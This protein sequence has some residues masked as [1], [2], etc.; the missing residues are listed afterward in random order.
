MST[1]DDMNGIFAISKPSGIT[2]STFLSKIQRI[3]TNSSVFASDLSELRGQK[4]QQLQKE[5]KGKASRRQL[6]KVEKVKIGHGG[7]LDPLASGVLVVGV[8]KGTKR[9]Q[10]YLNGSVKVYETEALFGIE[11][12][13]A[14][15]EGDV[16]LKSGYDHI[17]KE[18]LDSVPEK[19]LGTIKQTPPIFS[20][21]K[22][23]GKP[24]Y[25]YA[26]NNIALPKEIKSRE[27][28]VY[29]L[30]IFKDSLS[31]DYQHKG[32]KA[33]IDEEMISEL[34][35]N[36]T[37]KVD[38]HKVFYSKEYCAK[39]GLNPEEKQ[40]PG[41]PHPAT[42]STDVPPMLH[43][44]TKV[45]SGTYIRSLISDVA[46]SVQANAYMVKLIR[47]KQA[48]WDLNTNVFQMED[49][50]NRDD[51]VWGDVLRRVLHT[52]NGEDIKDLQI[53]F[54]EA[55]EKYKDQIEE[56]KR[57][58]EEREKLEQEKEE[59]KKTEQTGDEAATEAEKVV[60]EEAKAADVESEKKTEPE[61]ANDKKRPL[62]E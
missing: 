40:D 15:V 13:S 61:E 47:E 20:A 44:K 55:E 18:D 22:V 14:D 17:T 6:R 16:L 62:E 23:N 60:G 49:F 3:F 53:W 2:S 24:L 37:L 12:T 5:N 54:K 31:R 56:K 29:E 10:N 4:I 33:D 43:F 26:R 34:K 38:F 46:K 30:E 28:N 41:A 48:E 35:H 51:L 42:E 27:V 25:E 50:E 52:E 11:T 45:S 58:V 7:T 32:L 21:L 57:L 19:F 39:N 36:P 8:G 59:E 1:L 9:L